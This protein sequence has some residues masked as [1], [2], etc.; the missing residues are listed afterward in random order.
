V[1][2]H[3][4]RAG[5]ETRCGQ[6]RE[7]ASLFSFS[8]L[9]FRRGEGGGSSKGREEEHGPAAGRGG[10]WWWRW[11]GMDGWKGLFQ[12]NINRDEQVHGWSVAKRLATPLPPTESGF[13]I[14][15]PRKGFRKRQEVFSSGRLV[16]C[17]A[18]RTEKGRGAQG[19]DVAFDIKGPWAIGPPPMWGERAGK[20]MHS[21]IDAHVP[22]QRGPW[23]VSHSATD[24]G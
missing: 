15:Q 19:G 12:A 14:W 7:E 4:R 22:G 18:L 1:A 10:W 17:V 24:E 21:D 8:F 16:A 5:G 20:S 9:F 2:S 3:L 23:S 13:D 6:L 11:G